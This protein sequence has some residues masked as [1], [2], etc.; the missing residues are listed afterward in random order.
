VGDHLFE[1][2]CQNLAQTGYSVHANGLPEKLSQMLW[3]EIQGSHSVKFHK[4]GI[5]R[6]EDNAINALVRNDEVSWID[7]TTETGAAWLAWTARL[8]AYLNESLFL[9]LSSFESHFARYENG[10]FYQ[11]HHDAFRDGEGRKLSIVVYLNKNWEC[12][13]G[14][15][16]ILY[17]GDVHAT[18]IN[19]A[20]TFG[21]FVVFLSEE[22]PHEVLTTNR[23]RISV[24]GWFRTRNTIV[25]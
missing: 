5:G 22:I 25:N 4:A 18:E 10:G 7:D 12:K 6:G 1:I 17:T 14:G 20:P 8:Q 21:T 19:I 11:K 23:D 2:L 9:G 24:A 3:N 13:D 16:L 15:A